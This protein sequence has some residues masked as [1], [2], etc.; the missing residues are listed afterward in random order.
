MVRTDNMVRLHECKA[1]TGCM[2][3]DA[4][5]DLLEE[6]HS[7]GDICY[8]SICRCKNAICPYSRYDSYTAGAVQVPDA[9]VLYTQDDE[10]GNDMGKAPEDLSRTKDFRERDH[11]SYFDKDTLSIAKQAMQ[12]QVDQKKVELPNLGMDVPN[13][14]TIFEGLDVGESFGLI[15]EALEE[16]AERKEEAHRRILDMYSSDED[17]FGLVTKEDE[18]DAFV[19]IDKSDLWD[20]I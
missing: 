6:M 5:Y 3:N 11:L 14:Q 1:K 15:N 19:V 10:D 18:D 16:R 7:D 2:F 8:N 9:T 20:L 12:E 4:P 13:D 17:G